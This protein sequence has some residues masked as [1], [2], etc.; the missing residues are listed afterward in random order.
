MPV[1]AMSPGEQRACQRVRHELTRGFERE[2]RRLELKSRAAPKEVSLPRERPRPVMRWACRH[3]PVP[4]ATSV[5]VGN[6]TIGP[7]SGKAMV[8]VI[9]DWVVFASGLRIVAAVTDTSACGLFYPS[10]ARRAVLPVGYPGP[11]ESRQDGSA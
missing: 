3:L 9:N 11:S 4:A 7:R 2:K 8:G 1:Q 6:W 10:G 5:A